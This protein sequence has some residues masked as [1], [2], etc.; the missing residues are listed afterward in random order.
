MLWGMSWW[1]GQESLTSHWPSPDQL[2]VVVDMDLVY[3]IISRI[4]SLLDSG[5]VIINIFLINKPTFVGHTRKEEIYHLWHLFERGPSPVQ[6]IPSHCGLAI[7]N[8]PNDRLFLFECLAYELLQLSRPP[9]F[10]ILPEEIPRQHKMTEE[11]D[12]GWR[13]G[14]RRREGHRL[15]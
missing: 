7:A 10:F 13:W 12:V 6:P 8:V 1:L 2:V 9:V 11:V 15:R 5:C 4:D 3:N 14:R